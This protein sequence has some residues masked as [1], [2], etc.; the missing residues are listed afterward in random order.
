MFASPPATAS[1]VAALA[2]RGIDHTGGAPEV[3]GPPPAAR[4]EP[5]MGADQAAER[6]ARFAAATERAVAASGEA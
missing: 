1:G 4:Y 6:L 2:R 5:R 3:A